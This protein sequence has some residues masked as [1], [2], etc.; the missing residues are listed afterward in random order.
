MI[1]QSNRPKPA[2]DSNPPA[3]SGWS[4]AGFL[5][6]GTS[7]SAPTNP[8]TTI[9]TFTRKTEPHQNL[10]SSRPPAIGPIAMPSPMVPAHGADGTGTLRR[11]AEDVVDDRQRGGDR[12][13]RA[14]PHDRPPRDQESHRTRE[15]GARGGSAEEGQTDEEEAPAAESIGQTAS[16]QQEPGKDHRVG[17]DD[18]LQAARGRVQLAHK[19]RERHV[20]DRVVHVDHQGG[21]ADHRQGGSPDPPASGAWR[22]PR[23][24]RQAHEPRRLQAPSVPDKTRSPSPAS[25]PRI[26]TTAL[27][28]G[29]AGR[30]PGGRSRPSILRGPVGSPY[31]GGTD[32]KGG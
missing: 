3:G 17:V 10:A 23:S 12:Q 25:A 18:P 32:G 26:D 11:V 22:S 13:G 1:A 31:G 20:Q 8:A 15:P 7:S 14:Y 19:S 27:L 4:A 16:D 21:D 29:T 2:M 9:G 24:S 30:R 6:S 28:G 5:E